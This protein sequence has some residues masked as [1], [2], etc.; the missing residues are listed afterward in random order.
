M[1]ST[2]FA[3]RVDKLGRIVFPVELRKIFKIAIKDSL[4]IYVHGEQIILKK[5]EPACVFHSNAMDIVNNK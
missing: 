5:Y 4:E 1:K 2:G 3:R